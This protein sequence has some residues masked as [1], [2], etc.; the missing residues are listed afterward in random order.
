M[1]TTIPIIIIIIMTL[2]ELIGDGLL[3]PHSEPS[4]TCSHGQGV[5]MSTS[6]GG[7]QTRMVYLKHVNN[8]NNER[9]SRAPF[10]VKHAQLR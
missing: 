3:S 7:F 10:H 4:P 5:I 1:K 8:N 6:H 2:T 9:I